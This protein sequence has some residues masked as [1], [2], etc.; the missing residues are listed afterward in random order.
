M[1][2]NRRQMWLLT[3]LVAGLAASGL[4]LAAKPPKPGGG[5]GGG[6]EPLSGIIYFRTFGV[7]D[8][9]MNPD[10]SNKLVLPTGVSG[11]PSH[12]TYGDAGL[13]WFLQMRHIIGEKYPNGHTT[14]REMFVVREDGNQTVTVQLTGDANLE[15][16]DV[17]WSPGD[18][19][20]SAVGRRW[21]EA[22]EVDPES[23]GL[24]VATMGFNAAGDALGLDGAPQFFASFGVT[25]DSD[26]D[27][28]YDFAG[29]DWSPDLTRIVYGEDSTDSLRILDLLTNQS[30]F[31]TSGATPLWSPDGS[32]IAFYWFS[33]GDEVV[34]IAPDGRNR[35]TLVKANGSYGVQASA[36][37]P[38]GSHLLYFRSDR[39]TWDQDTYR[40]SATGGSKT[41]L[42]SDISASS[43]AIAWRMLP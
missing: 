9:V 37:S 36:W 24:Y 11:D 22:G 16:F 25:L 42:T 12:S 40:I 8:A 7:G 21:T 34:T 32:R 29:Y 1:L 28:T 26:G 43:G 39:I 31:L 23:V 14:R 18:V 13:R 27:W 38:S 41:N 20:V 10:G 3:A 35:K 6:D 2:R 30:Q 17:R 4:A 19:F 5:G 15:L 33:T